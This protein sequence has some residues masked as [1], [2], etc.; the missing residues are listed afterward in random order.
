MWASP[1]NSV[2]ANTFAGE[3]LRVT[4]NVIIIKSVFIIY[5]NAWTNSFEIAKLS[6]DS[7]EY[8]KIK[9]LLDKNLNT[10]IWILF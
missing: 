9:S 5:V 1:F 10:N 7:T 3:F 4:D 6:D 2:N 8:N